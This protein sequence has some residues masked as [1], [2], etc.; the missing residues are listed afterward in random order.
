M[1]KFLK[2]F[3]SNKFYIV[4]TIIQSLAIIM[5]ALGMVSGI[6]YALAIA[7]EGVFFVVWGIRIFY[8]NKEIVKKQN[9]IDAL[10]MSQ[11]DIDTMHKSNTRHIKAN[12]LQA[13]LFIMLGIVL[14]F[15]LII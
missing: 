1:K 3:F 4:L 11:S 10:P 14:I 6:F 5:L 13:I 12:K 15:M 8:Q 9:L 7:L 2:E